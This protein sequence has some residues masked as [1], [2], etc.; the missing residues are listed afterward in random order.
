MSTDWT[1]NNEPG[2]DP[3]PEAESDTEHGECNGC[4]EQAELQEAVCYGTFDTYTDLLCQECVDE[5]A[6]AHVDEARAERQQMGL[7]D[8]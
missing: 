3:G 1:D 7:V 2:F 5:N 8:F 6:T 4:G